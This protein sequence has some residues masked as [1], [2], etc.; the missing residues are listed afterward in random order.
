MAFNR[1]S[2]PWSAMK[3]AVEGRKKE[4][5]ERGS[6]S[7]SSPR[8]AADKNASA[9]PGF[10]KYFTEERQVTGEITFAFEGPK[11]RASPTRANGLRRPAANIFLAPSPIYI[12]APL[13]DFNSGQP[14]R[15]QE[16]FSMSRNALKLPEKPWKLFDPLFLAL[17]TY[18]GRETRPFL[19]DFG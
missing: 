16:R 12:P 9:G 6:T 7:E 19:C 8:V 10:I 17:E 4:R 11:A 18:R 2:D 14:S 3:G 5:R 13:K 1:K 15:F